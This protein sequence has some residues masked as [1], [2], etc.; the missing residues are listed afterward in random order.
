PL[1]P[2][3]ATLLSVAGLVTV[4]ARAAVE[5]ANAGWAPPVFTGADI[6][7]GTLRTARTNGAV[8]GVVSSLVQRLDVD[9]NGVGLGLGLGGLKPALAALLAP[10]GPVLD[11]LVD[12]LLGLKI[13][14]ADIRVHGLSCP[15]G[16]GL[17]PVLVG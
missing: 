5:A 10:I 7:G 13:G 9:V 1:A 16:G 6:D 2:G 14:E 8:G 3:R 4:T 12:P 11:G 15:E 17:R